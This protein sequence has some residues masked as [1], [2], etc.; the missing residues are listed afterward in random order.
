MSGSRR[1]G[2][3]FRE[4]ELNFGVSLDVRVHTP[5]GKGSPN[6]GSKELNYR[7]LAA[8]GSFSA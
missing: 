4:F 8:L 5:L 6:S 7:A 1:A 2:L 3:G